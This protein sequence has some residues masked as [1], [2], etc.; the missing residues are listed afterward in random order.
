MREFVEARRKPVKSTLDRF[1]MLVAM[2]KHP[3][4]WVL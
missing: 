2:I 3:D 1:L 4:R